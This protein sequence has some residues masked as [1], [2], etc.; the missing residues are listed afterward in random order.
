MQTTGEQNYWQGEAA[1]ETPVQPEQQEHTETVTWE[2]SEYVHHQKG[3]TWYLTC[4]GLGVVLALVSYFLLKSWTF[5]LLIIVS[6]AALVVFAQ[7]PPRTLAYRLTS[8]SLTIN[9]TEYQ[10]SE[11]KSF[12]IIQEGPLYSV[13]LIPTKRFMPAVNVYFP[14]EYGEH[15]VD[16]LGASLPMENFEPDFIERFMRKIRF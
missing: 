1:I 3:F 11:F 14:S 16:H 2:A 7:R 6:T 12:G 9:E 10:M 5:A 4:V 8:H 15:I 13:V